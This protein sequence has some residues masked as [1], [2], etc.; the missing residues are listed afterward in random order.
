MTIIDFP[1]K[2]EATSRK[3]P[4]Q[5][6]LIHNLYIS[7]D[8]F[9]VSIRLSG[10]EFTLV[11]LEKDPK[12]INHPWVR[13]ECGTLFG[14]DFTGDDDTGLRITFGENVELCAPHQ[15]SLPETGA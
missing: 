10:K 13:C 2:S 7:V 12:Q 15:G 11:A 14:A 1:S 3:R 9:P 5:P 6:V 4:H 8:G